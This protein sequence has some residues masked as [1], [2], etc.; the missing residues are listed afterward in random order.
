MKTQKRREK[1]CQCCRQN[2]KKTK[3][4]IKTLLLILQVG[5]LLLKMFLI[6]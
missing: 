1:R 5:L 2:E 4:D 3:V 6:L